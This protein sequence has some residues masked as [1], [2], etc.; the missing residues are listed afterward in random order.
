MSSR[1]YAPHGLQRSARGLRRSAACG[2]ASC[3]ARQPL[4]HRSGAAVDNQ[5]L[6]R[7]ARG[8]ASGNAV[9]RQC[10]QCEQHAVQRKALAV[11]EPHQPQEQEADHMAEAYVRGLGAPPM[12]GETSQPA[13]HRQA[14][15]S[16]QRGGGGGTDVSGTAL[17]QVSSSGGHA[18]EADTR[19]PYERFFGADLSF[20]RIHDNSAANRAAQ[21][22]DAHAFA[23]G[24]DL[25][26]AP[27]QFNP[28]TREGQRLLTHELTHVLQPSAS[29]S[30]DSDS[31]ARDPD[32]PSE[33]ISKLR[34]LLDD[35]KEQD[36]LNLM[37]KLSSAEVNQVLTDDS[38]KALAVSAFND[39]EMVTGIRNMG[40][41]AI[42]S[43]NWLFAEGVDFDDFEAWLKGQP[44]GIAEVLKS[45][46][47]RAGFVSACND[48]ELARALKILPGDFTTKVDWL[49][50]EDVGVDEIFDVVQAAP[51]DERKAVYGDNAL[52]DWFVGVLD[53]IKMQ[54]LVLELGGTLTNKLLWMKAEGS[55]WVLI[56]VVLTSRDVTPSE[57]AAV[58]DDDDLRQ[59]FVSELN[60][61]EMK[62]ALDIL[63]GTLSQKMHW[64]QAEGST[65][66][67]AE[68]QNLPAI[69]PRDAALMQALDSKSE[70]FKRFQ[71]AE[72]AR[73][74]VQLA[75]GTKGAARDKAA[76]D[77][78]S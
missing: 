14:R 40:G 2:G 54:N 62:Q 6:M 23:R 24:S 51:K 63:G 76:A 19:K 4:P 5:S 70:L 37:A 9:W 60:D 20:V 52:R 27:G 30:A 73:K 7:S 77:R 64:L 74:Q 18:L 71:E 35:D 22:L 8:T 15:G 61:E 65:A 34:Q 46:D 28:A 43:L 49:R 45:G 1:R 17:G 42:P 12:S 56:K 16:P 32:K 25:Y 3:N 75:T 53:D 48:A 72:A 26:F 44:K 13:V 67:P 78:K 41:S 57:K 66:V 59:F 29:A 47:M 58:L 55:S 10:A 38:M 31:V 36:A 21:E 50:E 39:T 11:S 68:A 69:E 33:K